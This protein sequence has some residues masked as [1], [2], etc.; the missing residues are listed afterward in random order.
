MLLSYLELKELVERG[1]IQNV[2]P[3]QINQSSIDIRLGKH[4]LLE[5]PVPETISLRKRDPL[6]MKEFV[7]GSSGYVFQPNEFML[8]ESIEK[9]NLPDNISGHFQLKSTS[10]RSAIDHLLAGWMDAG[11][12]GSVLTLELKNVSRYHSIHLLEGD[13]IGQ[14]SFF[15]HTEVP[16]EHSY[17]QRGRYNGDST[18]SGVKS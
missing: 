2:D 12:H 1:V 6:P 4:L 9:F 17:A 18:V 15:R 14:V 8:A 5:S 3:G 13:W 16:P 10:A 7:M 11:W